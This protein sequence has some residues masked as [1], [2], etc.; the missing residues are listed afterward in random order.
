MNWHEYG[1]I[2]RHGLSYTSH[3]WDY[4]RFGP[5][6]VLSEASQV[7]SLV[8]GSQLSYNELRF[9]RYLRSMFLGKPS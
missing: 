9:L 8:Y 6:L 1:V 7:H 4:R 5:F 2:G 3:I